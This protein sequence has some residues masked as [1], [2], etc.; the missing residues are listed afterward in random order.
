MTRLRRL[1]P[2]PAMVVACL[3]LLVALAGTSV[4]A[5]T[6]VIP[7]NSVGPLQLKANSVSSSK[8]QN[9]SLLAADFKTGQLPRGAP[10]AR[11]P[12][13]PVGPPG[14]AGPAGPA[15]A[16]G[17]SGVAAPGYV[18]EVLTANSTSSTETTSTSYTS[19]DNGTLTLT[20]PTGETAKLVVFFNAET[21]CYG[22]TAGASCQVRILVDNSEIAPAA[23]NDSTFDNNGVTGAVSTSSTQAQHAFTKVSGTLAAGS[24]TVKVEIGTSS[25]STTFRLDD[26]TLAVLRI[27][28]S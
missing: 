10:G 12:A 11:G 15:G 8:V 3:A 17:A 2:S 21:A 14:P 16:A 9:R 22:G 13:G 19:L 26:W 7:R 24:H 18:A 23:D 25:S 20:V 28:V 6:I 27:K 5:V 4:A 1:R